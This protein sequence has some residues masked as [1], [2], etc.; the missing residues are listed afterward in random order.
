M[1]ITIIGAGAMGSLF[2][3][4]L[5][6]SGQEV[7]LMDIWQEHIDAINTTG[8]GIKKDDE[9]TRTPV[10][11]SNRVSETGDA[12]LGNEFLD[13]LHTIPDLGRGGYLLWQLGFNGLNLGGKGGHNSD[14]LRG[15]G[16]VQEDGQWAFRWLG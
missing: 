13:F 11:A 1:K 4:L 5:A 12:D 3:A 9:T 14:L 2:G 15:K 8:L 16:R 10:K 7:L 6:R